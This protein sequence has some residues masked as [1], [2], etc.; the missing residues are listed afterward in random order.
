MALIV[1]YIKKIIFEDMITARKNILLPADKY[2]IGVYL[3]KMGLLL[4][5]L[6]DYVWSSAVEDC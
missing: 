6:D 5:V 3:V 2:T 1:Q 4:E